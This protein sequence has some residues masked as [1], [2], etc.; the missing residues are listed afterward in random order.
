MLY[1]PTPP[2]LFPLSFRCFNALLLVYCVSTAFCWY[3]LYDE[4][5]TATAGCSIWMLDVHGA[6]RLPSH[7]SLSADTGG[8]Q[9][10][11]VPFATSFRRSIAA[12]WH[13]LKPHILYI[14]RAVVC[15]IVRY[16]DACLCLVPESR[17]TNTAVDWWHENKDAHYSMY[18]TCNR[19]RQSSMGR[20]Y[21]K[22]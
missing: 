9:H 4:S 17:G 16:V 2:P 1:P 21:P 13:W 10:I 5:S 12:G 19:R 18:A 20:G 22:F 15:S 8:G 6:I 14:G 7:L 3:T 11:Q